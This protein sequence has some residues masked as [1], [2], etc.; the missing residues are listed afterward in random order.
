MSRT[1][2]TSSGISA[3]RPQQRCGRIVAVGN[4]AAMAGLSD[5]CEREIV[6]IANLYEAVGE[7]FRAKP[8]NPTDAVFVDAAIAG[9]ASVQAI[10]SLR[11]FDPSVQLVLVANGALCDLESSMLEQFDQKLTPPITRSMIEAIFTG[12]GA[13][14]APVPDIEQDRACEIEIE[15]TPAVNGREAIAAPPEKTR[16]EVPED[17]PTPP[18]AESASESL[19]D[20]DLVTAV[21]NDPNG[22]LDRAVE[23]IMEQTGWIGVKLLAEP[24]TRGIAVVHDGV[25]HGTLV[26]DAPRE[27]IEPWAQWLGYWMSLDAAFRTNRTLSLTDEL[28]G[29]WNRRYFETFLNDCIRR[30]GERRRPISV[31][32]LDLDDFKQYNDAFG[33][34]AGDEILRETVRLLSSV[35]RKGDRVCRIGGDEFVVIFADLE[36]PR[37]KGSDHPHSVEDIAQR[38][39]NEIC[40]MH[41]PKLGIEAPGTLSV[42]AGLATYPWDGHDA[43]SLLEHADQLALESKRRGKNALTMGPGAQRACGKH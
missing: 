43:H 12:G 11:R 22:V 21:M 30:A 18:P 27:D 13:A 15:R 5:A 26:A 31:M 32:V 1:F 29:A 9:M 37:E 24:T 38:F 39:Q 28:T 14:D 17:A 20:I 10:Q 34:A 2:A 19:G 35:I 4:P 16:P 6:N 36:G 23:L 33:H 3:D 41:F 8:S 42:S 25:F 40:Q 7:L